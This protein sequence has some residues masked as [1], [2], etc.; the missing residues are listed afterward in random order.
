MRDSGTVENILFSDITIHTQLHGP[1]WWGK[2]EPIYVTAIPRTKETKLGRVRNVR[3]SNILCKSENG[4]FIHGWEGSPIEDLVLDNVRVEVG[5]WTKW[6]GGFHD[7]RPGIAAGVYEHKTAGVYIRHAA[8]AKL[9]DVKVVWSE[10][11]PEYFGPVMES[12]DVSGLHLTCFEGTDAH[13]GKQPE[14]ARRE[15]WRSG[16]A[17]SR[18]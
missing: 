2:A 9:R 12:L 8:N 1:Q 18:Q 11:P 6:P 10:N 15:E 5:K 13:R 17:F 3:F 14:C 7:T 4:V 16:G